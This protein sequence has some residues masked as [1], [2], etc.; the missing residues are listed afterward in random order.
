MK[1]V[2]PQLETN[3]T[4]IKSVLEGLVKTYKG[5]EEEFGQFQ[6][7]YGIQVSVYALFGRACV[8]DE[9]DACWGCEIA[10][11][12]ASSLA[13]GGYEPHLNISSVC[14]SACII[15]INADERLFSANK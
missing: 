6:R 11:A 13:A 7:E 3:Y 1:E 2:V 9:T 14:T 10:S 12:S 5:K 15:G 8:A 4:G